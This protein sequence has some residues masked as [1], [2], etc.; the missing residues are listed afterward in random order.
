MTVFATDRLFLRP[1][2]FDGGEEVLYTL[3]NP[4]VTK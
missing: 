1:M 3:D 4:L 2:R